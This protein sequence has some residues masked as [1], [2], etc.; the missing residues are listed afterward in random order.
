MNGTPLSLRPVV[1]RWQHAGQ[2]YGASFHH[3]DGNCAWAH[4]PGLLW[5][6]PLKRIPASVVQR[7]RATRDAAVRTALV[8][9]FLEKANRR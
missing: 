8:E 7:I 9:P 3:A 4:G 1:Y 2:E 6:T 5:R